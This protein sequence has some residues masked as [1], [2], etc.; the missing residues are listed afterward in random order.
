MPQTWLCAEAA[1]LTDPVRTRT[2][3]AWFDAANRTRDLLRTTVR[4]DLAVA[5]LLL[6]WRGGRRAGDGIQNGRQGMSAVGAGGARQG[7]L[8]LAV[9]D[10]AA[11]YNAYMP[12]LKYGG[13]FVPTPKRYFLG[14]E[15]FLL[16]TLPESNERLP[17]AGKVVWVTPPGAQGN[18]TAGIGVQFADTRRRRER[19]GQDRN[20]AGR[21]A[22]RG[23]AHAHDVGSRSDRVN[24]QHGRLCARGCSVLIFRQPSRTGGAGLSRADGPVRLRSL[25]HPRRPSAV[26]CSLAAALALILGGRT[27][28]PPPTAAPEPFRRRRW[29]C[30]RQT[31]SKASATHHFPV[32]SAKPEVQRWFDQGL[33][34]TYGFNHDAAERSFLKAT[35]A[36]S[37]LRHV[38]VGRRARA[39]S[40]RQRRHGPREQRQG[41][42]PPAAGARAGADVRA[43]R[44]Q[45]FIE[46][47]SAR[48]AEKP[49]EDRRPLDEAY[50]AATG[51]LV[52]EVSGRPRRGDACTP[53]R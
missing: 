45:A 14:D 24:S 47:L 22:Q 8:S 52:R 46:A 41:L 53:R 12:Y 9:K 34:L 39:R 48:Y 6:A 19:Q 26:S 40:A 37:G 4:A 25:R 29:R 15:V 28:H 51:E 36:R 23:Q 50:A 16:L 49:P 21:H 38:L 1:G 2:L 13:I 30:R 35:R 32:T 42:G 27:T 18:R 11:L 44:E 33:M 10:K 43:T 20:A 7:I 17:V 31:C 5:E 3:A